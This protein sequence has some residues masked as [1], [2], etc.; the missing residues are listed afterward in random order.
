MENQCADEWIDNWAEWCQEEEAAE[1]GDQQDQ[2]PADTSA[3][4]PVAETDE[5]SMQKM[6]QQILPQLGLD[7]P[8]AGAATRL[9]E[10]RAIKCLEELGHDDFEKRSNATDE[11]KQAA[12]P[13]LRLIIAKHNELKQNE[14]ENKPV[15]LEVKG[16]LQL[17][18]SHYLEKLELNQWKKLAE[19]ISAR[20]ASQETLQQAIRTLD[21]WKHLTKKN[22][23]D[24]DEQKE[25]LGALE[26]ASWDAPE[27]QR[28][29]RA[30]QVLKNPELAVAHCRLELAKK[31]VENDKPTCRV[32]LLKALTDD[33]ELAK[34]AAFIDLAKDSGALENSS[35]TSKIRTLGLSPGARN[36]AEQTV[37][38][39]KGMASFPADIRASARLALT[40]LKR[41]PG[42]HSANLAI[43]FHQAGAA[44]CLRDFIQS[45]KSE[46]SKANINLKVTIEPEPDGKTTTV[47]IESKLGASNNTALED[48]RSQRQFITVEERTKIQ[49]HHLAYL[50][51][52]PAGMRRL[53]ERGVNDKRSSEIRKTA[54]RLLGSET[55]TAD[56]CK[57]LRAIDAACDILATKSPSE[58]AKGLRELYRLKAENSSFAHKYIDYLKQGLGEERFKRLESDLNEK[59][60]MA[61]SGIVPEVQRCLAPAAKDLDSLRTRIILENWESAKQHDLTG[62]KQILEKESSLG[63]DCAKI[64]LQKVNAK[65]LLHDI[66]NGSLESLKKL[67]TL[68]RDGNEYGRAALVTLTMAPETSLL[69]QNSAT[70][71]FGQRIMPTL[72]K[73]DSGTKQ[74]VQVEAINALRNLAKDKGL[75][76]SECAALA[77]ALAYETDHKNRKVTTLIKATMADISSKPEDHD[78]ETARRTEAL[79]EGIFTAISNLKSPSTTAARELIEQYVKAASS[80]NNRVTGRGYERIGES[81]KSHFKQLREKT[82]Q[83]DKVAAEI[84]ASFAGGTGSS[85]SSINPRRV[86]ANE[87]NSPDTSAM[88]AS[89]S[90][91]KFARIDSQN[92]QYAIKL[93]TA[94]D[95]SRH[96][97]VKLETLGR[98][99]GQ[100]TDN[101]AEEVRKALHEGLKND[102][103]RIK[104]LKGILALGDKL[105]DTDFKAIATNLN[106]EMIQHIRRFANLSPEQERLFSAHL[107]KHFRTRMNAQA[108]E[109]NLL[110]RMGQLCE[111]L[112]LLRSAYE[113]FNNACYI[114]AKSPNPGGDGGASI[115]ERAATIAS[116][117]GDTKKAEQHF[118]A[119]R[120]TRRAS[121][122][123]RLINELPDQIAKAFAILEK[124]PNK[125]KLDNG[126][127]LT[128]SADDFQKFLVAIPS[129]RLGP[130]DAIKITKVAFDGKQLNI[131]G[132]AKYQVNARGLDTTLHLKN[133]SCDIAVDQLN[134]NTIHLSNLKGLSLS[135]G[136]VSLS[137][138]MPGSI[139]ITLEPKPGGLKIAPKMFFG[140]LPARTIQLNASS[141][142][143]FEK[144]RDGLE[145]RDTSGLLL[146]LTEGPD[147][148]APLASSIKSVERKGDL[149]V[150]SS[151]GGKQEVGGAVLAW[152]KVIEARFTSTSGRSIKISDVK[153]TQVRIAVPPALLNELKIPNPISLALKEI[154]LDEPEVNGERHV[155]MKTK[156]LISAV[157][158]VVGPDLKPAKG[159]DGKFTVK[160][161][162]S[163]AGVEL[164]IELRFN[165]QDLAKDP[166]NIDFKIA[167]NNFQRKQF[168]NVIESLVKD[169][170][171]VLKKSIDGITSVEKR[172][173]NVCVKR[174]QFLQASHSGIQIGV[175]KELTFD[176]VHD[177][178]GLSV[179]N[180]KG[181]EITSLPEPANLVYKGRLPIVVKSFKLTDADDKGQRFVLIDAA[182]P[183]RRLVMQL[184]KS[185][186]PVDIIIDLENPARVLKQ[187]LQRLNVTNRL[188]GIKPDVVDVC[189]IRI[190]NNTIDLGVLKEVA[191]MLSDAGDLCSSEGWLFAGTAILTNPFSLNP[192]R[193][194]AANT[195]RKL[196]GR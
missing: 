194:I 23:K 75:T 107:V 68:A 153:G 9:A 26:T 31:L 92:K 149:V 187:N 33:S 95:C 13:A 53:A 154:S 82:E 103:N 126:K 62:C 30:K 150:V 18:M 164:P 177:K 129:L 134:R 39:R 163:K 170:D 56:L 147:A 166:S 48:R 22:Q 158:L 118:F 132:E 84:V 12:A 110:Q 184:D 115:H 156:G 59:S 123:E 45:L 157:E 57:G 93:L 52:F 35:F 19:S 101:V 69:W 186:S 100:D 37:V 178:F 28:M 155:R 90:L 44:G 76:G 189:R 81:I 172:G 141:R 145:K 1:E 10:Q 136:D 86:Q 49:E 196:E 125:I 42:E 11:L 117:L 43:A 138:L 162:I 195:I 97:G 130:T 99:A 168:A 124:L 40:D 32:Q 24:I 27:Q 174:D 116:R 140:S 21:Q 169:L 89:D 55:S 190:Q 102:A 17:I 96:N 65:L 63:N 20:D 60:T 50:S 112:G 131:E 36:D 192:A 66:E 152:D 71:V 188:L 88:L 58:V 181:L 105:D 79:L 119:A 47:V 171:P 151:V 108:D 46:F 182:G 173:C 137:A 144:I 104:A 5:R 3:K 38:Q 148:L 161:A 159:P 185:M 2:K 85:N 73:L 143:T 6:P 87:T 78:I 67:Y 180:I 16:R 15:D 193:K 175:A 135:F 106:S 191:D 165:P 91:L 64:A 133:F 80:P 142:K 127:T 8:G 111:S 128:L 113:H 183:L 54:I 109:V 179:T 25:L 98:L 72:D 34:D 77:L 41:N 139:S 94:S 61:V 121:S 114:I 160:L 120:E 14:R 7:L 122:Y 146:K 167:L 83:G 176:L 70:T 29:L 51:E 74:I 4:K